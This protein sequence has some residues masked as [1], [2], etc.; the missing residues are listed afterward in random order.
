MSVSSPNDH[1]QAFPKEELG[2]SF[3]YRQGQLLQ[4]LVLCAEAEKP[5]TSVG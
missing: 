4:E 3:K 5:S 1:L 2:T